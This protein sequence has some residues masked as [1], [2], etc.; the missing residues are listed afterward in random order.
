M[1]NLIYNNSH[2][3]RE[4]ERDAN[5]VFTDYLQLSNYSDIKLKHSPTSHMHLYI[6]ELQHTF[7]H[8]FH[9]DPIF[10]IRS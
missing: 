1:F 7:I 5:L 4:M 8:L 10:P 2:S 6:K 9:F 3:D